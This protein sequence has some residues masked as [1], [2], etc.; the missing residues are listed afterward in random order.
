M[1]QLKNK[2]SKEECLARL[3]AEPFERVTISFYKYHKIEDPLAFRNELF[4]EWDELGVFG[5]VYVA[6]EGINAQIS[7]PEQNVDEFR[8]KL[9]AREGFDGLRLNIAVE[10]GESFYRLQIKVRKQIVAD[11]LP[12]DSYDIED[13]GQH[14]DAESFNAALAEGVT[15]VD[16]RNFYESRIGHFEGAVCPDVDTFEEQLPMVKDMLKGKEDEKILLYC[17]GGIRCEKTS[18]Y[19]KHHGFKDVNQLEGGIIKYTRDVKAKGLE[20][21]FRGKNFVFDERIAEDIN[22][23]VIACCDRCGDACDDYV[24]CRNAACNL[25]FIQCAECGVAMDGTCTTECQ[26]IVHLP[27]AERLEY[28]RQQGSTDR[29]GYKSRLRPHLKIKSTA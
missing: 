17:T 13:V 21:K 14:L 5:R 29:N 3:A 28:Y 15:C 18:A 22:G 20:N 2:L 12:V 4:T 7:V 16:M 26:D 8:A 23:E 9:Y 25:L 1:Y 19:L 10:Q 11:G 24:N 6:R 27:E